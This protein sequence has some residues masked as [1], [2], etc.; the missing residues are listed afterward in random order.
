VERPAQQ[1][2]KITISKDEKVQHEN[3]L[4]GS[5]K[6]LCESKKHV[7]RGLWCERLPK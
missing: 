2:S 3:I 7:P 4:K 6:M 5:Y 1:K